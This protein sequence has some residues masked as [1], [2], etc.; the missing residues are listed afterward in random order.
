MSAL[1]FPN[2]PAFWDTCETVW[3][4]AIDGGDLD[5]VFRRIYGI[6]RTRGAREVWRVDCGE[7]GTII[8][9]HHVGW[10]S[11]VMV[12]YHLFGEAEIRE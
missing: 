1:S 5:T 6:S 9:Y 8:G 2:P 10:R 4:E 12:R 11:M 7:Y 3:S